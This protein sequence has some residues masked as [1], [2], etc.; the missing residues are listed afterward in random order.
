MVCAKSNIQN[1]KKNRFYIL[2]FEDFILYLLLFY[3][4]RAVVYFLGVI[5]NNCTLFPHMSTEKFNILSLDIKWRLKLTHLMPQRL[6]FFNNGLLDILTKSVTPNYYSMISFRTEIQTQ[7]HF[8]L[9]KFTEIYMDH[10]RGLL[11]LFSKQ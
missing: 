9:E 6:H 11:E 2:S 4:V 8:E 3:V 7:P 10:K 5:L 1:L